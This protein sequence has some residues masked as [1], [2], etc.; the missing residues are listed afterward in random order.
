MSA[1]LFG[2]A[3]RGDDTSDSDVD[4]AVWLRSDDATA[5]FA[6]RRRLETRLGCPV[7]IV[8]GERIRE[9]P[10]LLESL[11]L[12][13][14]MPVDRGGLWPQLRASLPRIRRDA[15]RRRRELAEHAQR[16]RQRL[17]ARDAR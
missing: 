9:Q 2:S 17:A 15:R 3:A 16:A 10:T 1:I 13:G 8:D 12:D 7:Q 6:L 14:R 5:R 11:L 4:I